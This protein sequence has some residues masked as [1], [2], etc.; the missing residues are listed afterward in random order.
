MCTQP[1]ETHVSDVIALSETQIS[2]SLS[3]L[4]DDRA[5]KPAPPKYI[6]GTAKAG[7]RQRLLPMERYGT[8]NR[9]K[10]TKRY[11]RQNRYKQSAGLKTE[12]LEK[13]NELAIAAQ[14]ED[15]KCW[16][17]EMVDTRT[18]LT[19]LN[20]GRIGDVTRG[21]GGT[22]VSPPLNVSDVKRCFGDF[23]HFFT[24]SRAPQS[25]TARS[26]RETKQS[27]ADFKMALEYGNH[28][29]IEKHLPQI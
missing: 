17:Y 9:K 24:G 25:S 10:L 18:Q 13:K 6:D 15:K 7:R 28:R 19:G 8:H 21:I 3:H 26:H 2:R 14:P 27:Q 20:G 4:I 29:T 11:S 1:W 16:I 12:W 23:K 5:Q 22:L